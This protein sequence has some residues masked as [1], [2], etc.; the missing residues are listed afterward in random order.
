MF[1]G[2]KLDVMYV[3]TM[4]RPM[5][6]IPQNER[7]KG[8]LFAVTG[9]GVRGLPERRIAGWRRRTNAGGAAVG[10]AVFLCRVNTTRQGP[11]LHAYP[12][13]RTRDA[14]ARRAVSA[15]V[16]NVTD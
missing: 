1:G 6:G 16:G 8:R 10:C 9:L 14:G 2:P 4:G 12:C 3:T 11:A 5:W 7:D 13:A 15:V